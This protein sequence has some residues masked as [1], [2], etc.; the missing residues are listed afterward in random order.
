[1]T[2]GNVVRLSGSSGGYVS[3]Q[4]PGRGGTAN[5]GYWQRV[6]DDT[7][8]RGCVRVEVFAWWLTGVGLLLRN[9]PLGDVTLH[10]APSTFLGVILGAALLALVM[11]WATLGMAGAVRGNVFSYSFGVP[12]RVAWPTPRSRRHGRRYA[13]Q[14]P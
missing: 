12:L 1:M 2:T 14:T 6:K 3:G 9:F 5:V 10:T 8:F 13:R 7:F 11:A 4:V